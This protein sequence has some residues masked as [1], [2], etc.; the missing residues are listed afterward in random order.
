M[1]EFQLPEP[2]CNPL[3]NLASGLQ[4]CIR[5]LRSEVIADHAGN[6]ML[7]ELLAQDS[8]K[9]RQHLVPALPSQCVVAQLQ[10][11]DIE[12]HECRWCPGTRGN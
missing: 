9:L 2:T 11:I 4:A 10:A 12:V 8:R 1:P 6:R 3:T 7:R 5:Q